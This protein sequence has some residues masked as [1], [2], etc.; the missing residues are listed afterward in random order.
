MY[1]YTVG[2]KRRFLPGYKKF[3]VTAHEPAVWGNVTVFAMTM[4]DGSYVFV[5]NLD[6]RGVRVYPDYRV[7]SARLQADKAARAA[8]APPLEG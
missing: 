4:A 1:V 2:V 7:A 6:R 3:K 8:E 5:S